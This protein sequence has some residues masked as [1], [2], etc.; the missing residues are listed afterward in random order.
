LHSPPPIH[1]PPPQ[2]VWKNTQDLGCGM[3]SCRP[4]HPQSAGRVV[5]V[6][7]YSPGGNVAKE[8]VQN[9][10]VRWGRR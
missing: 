4:E 6:C 8:Y 3:A 1:P 7:R 2:L 10:S 9:V 5:V